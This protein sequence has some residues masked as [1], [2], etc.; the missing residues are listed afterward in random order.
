MQKEI[1][2][3]RP[4]YD[5]AT[6]YLFYYAGLIIKESNKRGISCIDLKRPRLTRE[7]FTNITES[8]SPSFIFFNAHG[9]EKCIYGD[10]IEGD[11]EI[12]IEE[13][14]NHHL[15]NSRLI[16]TRACL[17]AA[18]LGKA[19]KDG[20]FIGYK[21]PFSFWINEKWSAKPSNDNTAKLFLEPSNMI[22][23]SILK[24]NTA[25]EAVNK[26]INI[27]KKNILRLLNE[28]EEPGA[29]ASIMLLWN[30]IEGI[31]ILGNKDMKFE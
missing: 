4:N 23:S 31:E 3:T 7:I 25:K 19:C 8:R 13:G 22:V 28:K 12:L 1:L 17:S 2:I 6:G 10:K 30:N 26:S 27:S 15:L 29:T 11:E 21:A 20:C 18:S 9:N 5:D 14:K 16:Y 24:G